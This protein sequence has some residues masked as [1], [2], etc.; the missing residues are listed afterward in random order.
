MPPTAVI[1]VVDGFGI[2]AGDP[3]DAVVAAR[4]SAWRGLNE[5]WPH[6]RLKASGPAVGLPV[7]QMGNSEVGHLNIGSG[8]HVP[9]DL[10]RID[11]AI[12]DGTFATMPNLTAALH[13]ARGNHLHLITL[14]G[15]GGV[16][17]HDRHALALASAAE[18]AGI[19]SVHIHLILDGR[20]TPPR[21]AVSYLAEFEAGL[22]R[23]APRARIVTVTGRYYAMDRDTHWERTARAVAA[24]AIGVG[25][26][27]A[28]A[29]AAV[30][31]AYARGESDEFAQPTVIGSWG[32][33]EAL[34][35]SDV[36]IHCNYRADRA[37]QLARV[38]GAAEF[39]DSPRPTSLPVQLWGMTQ[40]TETDGPP[41]LFPPLVV[42]SL[43][44]LYEAAGLRQFHVAETE[45]YAH[46]TYFFN[47]RREGPFSG[48]RR[49]LIP[50]SR[51]ATYDL[52]P[53]MRTSE[54]ADAVC[55]AVTAGDE[56]LIVAN[57]ASPDMV[58]HTG[59]LAA[60]TIACEAAD[61]AIG[62]IADACAATPGTLLFITGDHGNA[63]AM[64]APDGSPKTSHTLND[65][66]LLIAGEAVRGRSLHDGELRDIAPTLCTL[67]GMAPP[68]SMTG[69]SLLAEDADSSGR[70]GTQKK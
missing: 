37:R 23:V 36:I 47:G 16:H 5:S 13:A 26:R 7:G 40:Y 67:V 15:P 21:S 10:P 18:A 43:A 59:N 64:R 57:I 25:E 27:A 55:A 54:I 50:S 45:K 1:L 41:A 46:V 4:M 52:E 48:E 31:E 8:Q 19:K 20:D 62:R 49:L 68:A 65:V 14:L 44:A 42:P 61:L 28:T 33:G 30:M 38:L 2:G 69:H 9:Q 70:L 22:A 63:E 35:P 11:A 34:Q 12:A 24:I 56:A 32:S 58:G 66:P 60:A 39:T 3:S 53:A 51:V 6:A 17:G 29:G